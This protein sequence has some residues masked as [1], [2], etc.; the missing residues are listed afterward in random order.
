M[1][2]LLQ[3]TENMKQTLAVRYALKDR[4]LTRRCQGLLD[5]TSCLLLLEEERLSS[6][7]CYMECKQT[8]VMTEHKKNVLKRF[9]TAR[10]HVALHPPSD[11]LLSAGTVC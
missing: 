3:R 5:L 4:H 7:L 6:V 1:L 8:N 10:S 2:S 9:V 11:L